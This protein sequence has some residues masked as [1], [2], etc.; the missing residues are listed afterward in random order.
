M[1]L[2]R[3][4]CNNRSYSNSI[5]SRNTSNSNSDVK[6]I[7]SRSSGI[8]NIR[9]DVRNSNNGSCRS[10]NRI[11]TVVITEIITILLVVIELIVMVVLASLPYADRTKLLPE[12]TW[13]QTGASELGW[14]VCS[15]SRSFVSETVDRSSGNGL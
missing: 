8:N 15:A 14:P 6:I 13:P 12:R 1:K 3:R 2:E 5:G 9:N 10:N 11:T 4:D 7:I